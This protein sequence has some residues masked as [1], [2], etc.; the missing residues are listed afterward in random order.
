MKLLLLGVCQRT[1]F[2]GEWKVGFDWGDDRVPP[3][4]SMVYL[5][6]TP[7]RINLIKTCVVEEGDRF[8]IAR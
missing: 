8:S 4:S 1:E 7:L 5:Y 3:H 6:V 2:H